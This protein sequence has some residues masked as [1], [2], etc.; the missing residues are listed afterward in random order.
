MKLYDGAIVIIV[1]LLAVGVVGAIS[2]HFMWPDNPIEEASEQL[3]EQKTG[4]DID[5]SPAT[6]EN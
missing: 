2:Q 6:P 3:I 1:V 4:V 5:L